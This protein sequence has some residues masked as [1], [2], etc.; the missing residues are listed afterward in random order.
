MELTFFP[1]ML[2]HHAD[3]GLGRSRAADFSGTSRSQNL[4]LRYLNSIEYAFHEN[5]TTEPRDIHD[6][7]KYCLKKAPRMFSTS[8]PG[9]VL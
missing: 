1:K 7:V 4:K 6:L 5:L 9:V 3:L 8:C 2:V